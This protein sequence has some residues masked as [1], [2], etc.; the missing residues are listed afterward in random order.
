MYGHNRTSTILIRI[1]LMERRRLASVG[2]TCN[3]L[4]EHVSGARHTERRY[5]DVSRTVQ[6]IPAALQALVARQSH[7]HGPQHHA[8]RAARA[9]HVDHRTAPVNA[10][11]RPQ[12]AGTGPA[13]S[14]S[15]RPT[16]LEGTATTLCT[17]HH[18]V[19]YE[20][21]A[22]LTRWRRELLTVHAKRQP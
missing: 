5:P 1:E 18:T 9:R 2:Y 6:V 11:S 15:T 22:H 16:V 12:L 20:S 19:A 14:A 10:R 21:H 13:R 17:A 3:L 4:T 8:T 7:H